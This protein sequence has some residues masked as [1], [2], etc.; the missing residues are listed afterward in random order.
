MHTVSHVMTVFNIGV[1][2]IAF[3]LPT[4]PMQGMHLI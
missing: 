2:I 1:Q 4:V 3:N